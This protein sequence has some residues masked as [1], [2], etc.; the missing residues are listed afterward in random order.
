MLS[1][2]YS[3]RFT[4]FLRENNVMPLKLV[5]GEIGFSVAINKPFIVVD[6]S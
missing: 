4:N 3:G 1:E 5:L 6:F 2:K